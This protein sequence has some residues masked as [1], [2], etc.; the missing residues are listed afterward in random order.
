LINE[1]DCEHFYTVIPLH[2]RIPCCAS[3]SKSRDTLHG[4]S[5]HYHSFAKH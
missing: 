1:L 2:K 4:L 5:K 3:K